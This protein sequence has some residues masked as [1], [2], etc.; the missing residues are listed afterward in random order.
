MLCNTGGNFVDDFNS[1]DSQDR[2]S[3]LQELQDLFQLYSTYE[4][5]DRIHI[6]TDSPQYGSLLNY[7]RTGELSLEEALFA[8][9]KARG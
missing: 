5:S 3:S 8:F 6:L 1:R 2:S 7:V 4:F 9:S